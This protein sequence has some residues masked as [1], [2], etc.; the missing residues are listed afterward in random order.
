[1]FSEGSPKRSTNGLCPRSHPALL[2]LQVSWGLR[3]S[4]PSSMEAICAPISKRR[5]LSPRAR[6]TFLGPIALRRVKVRSR[7]A[8][9][10]SPDRRGARAKYANRRHEGRASVA[11]GPEAPTPACHAACPCDPS[12][13]KRAHRSASGSRSQRLQGCRNQRRRSAGADPNASILHFH[14]N[15]VTLAG[16]RRRLRRRRLND[17]G[18]KS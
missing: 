18:R 16:A 12:R 3:Q 2:G 8:K 1:M 10:L 17:N 4:I 5:P 14:H 13:C 9:A 6:R 7:R 15:D 11:P